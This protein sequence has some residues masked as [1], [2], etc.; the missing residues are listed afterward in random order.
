MSTAQD[1]GPESYSPDDFECFAG[2]NEN[3]DW[4]FLGERAL[5]GS[6][7][8]PADPPKTCP[9]RVRLEPDVF[10]RIAAQRV[11]D[12][13]NRSADISFEFGLC[14]ARLLEVDDVPEVVAEVFLARH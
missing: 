13:A 9:R 3:Y 2:K 1:S 11:M 4:R 14:Y 12:G 6:I 7:N 8:D 10:W 5:L